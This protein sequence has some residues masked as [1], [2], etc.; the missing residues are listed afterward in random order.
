MTVV[1]SPATKSTEEIVDKIRN[2]LFV[3]D[4]QQTPRSRKICKVFKKWSKRKVYLIEKR[5]YARFKQVFDAFFR[6]RK[7]ELEPEL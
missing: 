5:R 3:L 1:Y 7:Q 2:S 4:L 6:G